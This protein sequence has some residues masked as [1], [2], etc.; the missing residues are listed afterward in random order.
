MTQKPEMLGYRAPREDLASRGPKRPAAVRARLSLIL[1]GV[2]PLI[3]GIQ[4]L[5]HGT[6]LGCDALIIWAVAALFGVAAHF[7]AARAGPAGDGVDLLRRILQLNP[8]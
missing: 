1:L 3:L 2:Y 7:C 6:A 8:S 4:W 5:S